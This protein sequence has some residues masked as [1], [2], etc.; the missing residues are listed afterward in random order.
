[1]TMTSPAPTPLPPKPR[2][3]G[4][5]HQWGAL[6]FAALGIALV[7]ATP[8]SGRIAVAIYA[9]CI[10]TML[11]LS[12]LYHRVPW[13]PAGNARMQRADHTGIF[14]AIAGTYTPIAVI[15]LHGWVQAALLIPIWV[16]AAAG[17]VIEW[18]PKRPPRGYATAVYLT[19]G[20]LA[21]LAL[22]AVWD[23]IGATGFVLL[24]GGGLLY[25]V[26]AVVHAARRP[27]PWPRVFGFHEIWHAFV[28]A[29]ALLHF[30]CIAFVVVP[31]A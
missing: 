2:L 6:V 4:V 27:D 3:R 29:A 11:T 13:S 15:A 5:S 24:L 25:T 16:L 21:V 7:I 28:L 18:L 20:W 31:L 17:M 8:P 12:A 1:M 22:P 26:G 9:I 30:V 14:L 10:T 23:A 19:M